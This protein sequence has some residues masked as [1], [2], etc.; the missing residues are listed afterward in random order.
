M[1][2]IHIRWTAVGW[3]Y[4]IEQQM[5]S[6]DEFLEKDEE[7]FRKVQVTDQSNFE[8]RLDTLQV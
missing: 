1:N 6:T 8:D 2:I 7:R 3:P 5:K 4:K